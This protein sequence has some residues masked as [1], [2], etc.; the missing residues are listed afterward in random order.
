[1]LRGEKVRE[2][3]L[4][5]YRDDLEIGKHDLTWL[6][7]LI[8]VPALR[9]ALSPAQLQGLCHVMRHD[10]LKITAD[11]AGKLLAIVRRLPVDCGVVQVDDA[12]FSAGILQPR[13]AAAFSAAQ[14]PAA[15]PVSPL[16]QR[17]HALTTQRR[18]DA[19]MERAKA[20][21]SPGN[22]PAALR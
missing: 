20:A 13:T 12:L 1:M 14:G 7:P 11:N 18:F 21:R 15:V 9:G 2:Y 10:G 3:V 8:E 4:S 17:I 16:A 19:T 6:R 22:Q 5:A